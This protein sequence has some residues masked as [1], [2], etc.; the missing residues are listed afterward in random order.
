V[1]VLIAGILMSF[2]IPDIRESTHES[3]TLAQ[4]ARLPGVLRVAIGWAL[5]MLAHFVVLTTSTP[6]SNS[7]AHPAT[8]PASPCPS[9]GTGIIGTL[10]IGRVA[11]RSIFAALIA[12]PITVAAGFIVLFLG[13]GSVIVALTGV[14]LWGIG[15]AAAVVVY[16][17]AILRTW[18]RAPEKA[19]SIGVLLAQTGFAAG[20]AVG[21]LSINA[22]G[23]ASLPLVALAFVLG[24]I[25]I[26]ITLRPVLRRAR[27]VNA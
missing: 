5:V 1:L 15:I 14:A 27:D 16:Q 24:S 23:I 2:V 7:S 6:T 9:S 20:A 19:T 25:V 3:L 13:G 11:S 26:A 10:F 4:A 18:S 22:V 17:Q 8:S 21:G 12:A